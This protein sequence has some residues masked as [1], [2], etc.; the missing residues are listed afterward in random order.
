MTSW[1]T[2]KVAIIGCGLV[3][4]TI[5]YSLVEQGLFAEIVLL[6]ADKSRAEGEALDLAHSM[7][8]NKPATIY[9]GGYDEIADADIIIMSAGFNRG[10]NDSRMDL[11]QKNMDVLRSIAE[12]VNKSGFMGIMLVVTNPVDILTYGATQ[13]LNLPAGH[14]IGSGTMLDSARFKSALAKLLGFDPRNVHA[15]IIGEHGDSELPVWSTANVSGIPIRR[16]FELKGIHNADEVMEAVAK[17]VREGGSQIIRQKGA[18]YFGVAT[19]VRHICE[20]IMR[21]EN[22]IMTVSSVVSD[23]PA[24]QGVAL[25]V[26]CVIGRDGIEMVMPAPISSEERVMLEESASKLRS[27]IDQVL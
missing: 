22:S 18:T 21:D 10:P 1:N 9:A 13:L 15:G 11:A 12:S 16:C 17:E 20:A 24:L 2:S 5:A 26:P 14:V 7:P 8:F 3:G 6:D 23:D 4:S 25:S 19:A 27:I